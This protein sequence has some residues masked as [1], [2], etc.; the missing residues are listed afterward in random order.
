MNLKPLTELDLF[1]FYLVSDP[2]IPFGSIKNSEIGLELSNYGIEE[3]SHI[4]SVII[5]EE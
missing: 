4:K 1:E 5:K 3:F 2:R